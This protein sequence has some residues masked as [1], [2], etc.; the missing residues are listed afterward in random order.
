MN[1][2]ERLNI[3]QATPKHHEATEESVDY[4]HICEST[5]VPSVLRL[6][7]Y[8]QLAHVGGFWSSASSSFSPLCLLCRL[9]FDHNRRT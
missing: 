4:F 9:P 6:R 8:S 1:I 2:R 5:A 7:S 3:E